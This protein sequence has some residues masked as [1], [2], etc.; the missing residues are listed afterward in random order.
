MFVTD[1]LPDSKRR[2]IKRSEKLD[3]LLHEEVA[4]QPLPVLREEEVKVFGSDEN[5]FVMGMG[6]E[7]PNEVAY[8]PLS[9]SGGYYRKLPCFL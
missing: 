1:L 6:E 7:E 5:V 3:G 4:I 8:E 9:V 2:N